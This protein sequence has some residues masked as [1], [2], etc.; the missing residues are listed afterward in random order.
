M[1]DNADLGLTTWGGQQVD[2]NSLLV[3]V[4]PIAD[5]TLDGKVDAHDFNAWYT[6]RMTDTYSYAAGDFNMDGVID[7]LDFS[8]WE[9]ALGPSTA[10]PIVENLGLDPTTLAALRAAPVPEPASLALA[11]LTTPW[12]LRRRARRTP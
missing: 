7:G 5:A 1:F 6:H 9:N 4:V 12:L 3:T 10:D 11:L 8:I 2:T